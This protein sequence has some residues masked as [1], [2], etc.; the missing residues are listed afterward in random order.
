MV[1]AI[2]SALPIRS[3]GTKFFGN[4]LP[5]N[6]R[7]TAAV[8]SVGKSV[9]QAQQ[10][11]L[12]KLLYESRRGGGALTAWSNDVGPDIVVDQDSPKTLRQVV[13][14]GLAGTVDDI[15]QAAGE[16]TC[17]ANRYDLTSRQSLRPTFVSCVEQLKKSHDSEKDSGDIC[18]QDVTPYLRVTVVEVI[19]SHLL[20]V[21]Q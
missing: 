4:T 10:C 15:G 6:V 8:M 13:D 7:E 21:G 2:S 5:P 18:F 12:T 14:T 11:E 19:V 16:T 20:R 17:A 9:A 1:P 3:N